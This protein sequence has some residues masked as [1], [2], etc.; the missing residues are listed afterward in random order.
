MFV[1]SF[2]VKNCYNSDVTFLR[3]N[4]S[5]GETWKLATLLLISFISSF[6]YH[7]LNKKKRVEQTETIDK[8]R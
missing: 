7:Y 8:M 4:I 5:N 3:E 1:R 2:R 6:I